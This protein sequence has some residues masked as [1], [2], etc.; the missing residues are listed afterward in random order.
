MCSA[1]Q[2][3]RN[4]GQYF[5]SS[6][7]SWWKHHRSLCARQQ[8]GRQAL[9]GIHVARG[10]AKVLSLFCWCT[11]ADDLKLSG[12]KRSLQRPCLCLGDTEAEAVHQQMRLRP[13]TYS[14]SGSRCSPPADSH[15]KP[16]GGAASAGASNA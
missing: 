15:F 8:T 4:Q 16:R 6:R 14:Q 10:L 3:H 5:S 7:L 2:V 1:L 11:D 12:V 13:T 9:I